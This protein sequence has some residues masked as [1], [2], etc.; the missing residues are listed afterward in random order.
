MNNML[1]F[2]RFK[3]AWG[4]IRKITREVL[5]HQGAH[6][7][8]LPHS[9]FCS[10]SLLAGPVI[11]VVCQIFRPTPPL[12]CAVFR[13]LELCRLSVAI[14]TWNSQLSKEFHRDAAS[15]IQACW[16]GSRYWH[17]NRQATRQRSLLYRWVLYLLSCVRGRHLRWSITNFPSICWSDTYQC[18]HTLIGHLS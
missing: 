11:W 12:C 4:I 9:L 6:L 16:N 18:F 5:C 8:I 7:P 1:N 2:C 14:L 3:I 13:H 10:G 15:K 17:W